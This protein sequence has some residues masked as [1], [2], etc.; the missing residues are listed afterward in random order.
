MKLN[1][2]IPASFSKELDGA[3]QPEGVAGHRPRLLGQSLRRDAPEVHH[4]LRSP[5]ARS[6]SGRSRHF[7]LHIMHCMTPNN[8]LLFSRTLPVWYDAGDGH[9]VELGAAEAAQRA[10]PHHGHRAQ[11]VHQGRME[12]S[13]LQHQHSTYIAKSRCSCRKSPI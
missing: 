6:V 12:Y 1:L 11:D 2:I 5:V 7:P 8:L 13:V 4:R 3:R 10:H 9:A